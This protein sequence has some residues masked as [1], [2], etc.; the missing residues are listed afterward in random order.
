MKM[1]LALVALGTVLTSPAFAQ[2]APN[3][4]PEWSSREHVYAPDYY[5]RQRDNRNADFQL[6][7]GEK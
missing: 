4:R 5:A 2:Q 7:S 3:N 1:I 6:G